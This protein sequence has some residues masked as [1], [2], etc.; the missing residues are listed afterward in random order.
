MRLDL[1]M[2]LSASQLTCYASCPRKYRYR[3]VDHREPETRSRALALGTAFHGALD[4]YFGARRRGEQLSGEEVKDVFETDLRTLFDVQGHPLT[5]EEIEEAVA[6]GRGLLDA[7]LA[8]CAELPA[9]RTELEFKLERGEGARPLVGFFDLVLEDGTIVEL[10]TAA[11]R[12]SDLDLRTNLQFAAYRWAGSELGASGVRII[13]VTKT[14]VPKVQTVELGVATEHQG[15]WF[16]RVARDVE[17]AIESGAF[18]PSPG[19]MCGG[20]EYAQACADETGEGD[21]SEAA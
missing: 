8:E 19:P 3:Y 6:E 2:H 5:A 18:P 17:K 1:P 16:L 20:C 15:R 14:K 11:R 7:F 4:V 13:A 21:A 10:K 12:Y 9:V